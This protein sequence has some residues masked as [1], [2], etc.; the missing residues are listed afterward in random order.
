MSSRLGTMQA[1]IF[2]P[3]PNG[4]QLSVTV[5]LLPSAHGLLLPGPTLFPGPLHSGHTPFEGASAQAARW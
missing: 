4:V 3:S 5:I 1:G 2:I